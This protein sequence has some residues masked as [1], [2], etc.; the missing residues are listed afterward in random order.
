[1]LQRRYHPSRLDDI[2]DL[3]LYRPGGFHPVSI[4]DVFANGRYKVLHKLGFGG[5]STVWLARDQRPQGQSSVSETLV[6]LKV[7]SAE[8]STKQRDEVAELVIPFKLDAL[9]RAAPNASCATRHNV[10][11]VKDYFM[12]EGPNGTH[13]CIV[14]QFAGSSLLSLSSCP[15]RVS[16]SRRLRSDLARKVAKQ[17]A[18]VIELM[19]SAGLL[20]GD[21]TSSNILF[22]VPDHARRWSD[23]EIYLTLG[24]PE[25]EEIVTL[26]HSP[27]GP[28]APREL[29]EPVGAACLSSPSLLQEDIIV[30][31]FGQSF[32]TNRPPKDYEPATAIHYLS[33]EAR[34]EN[35]ISLASDIWALA[36]IIFEIRAGSPLFDSFFGDDTDIVRETVETL[37]KLP[38]PWWSAFEH[39]SLW[40]EENGKPKPIEIQEQEG[41][42][43]PAIESS[44]RQKLREIGEQD[45]PPYA[46]EGPMMESIGTRLEE[47]EVVLLGDLLEKML[48]YRPEER[49]TIKEVVRHPWFNYT[50]VQ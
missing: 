44:I 34:F 47:G 33:P 41:V 1:M 16:G 45:E 2:E 4:G 13:L 39:R 21:L 31:D 35:R 38:E 25:T 5:S 27:P 12:K 8:K 49:I 30:I 29:V 19:H 28:C 18:T 42:L 46:D 37:G 11:V 43:L 10:Q 15:G 17:I 20:H 36:C 50:S 9:I 7:L 26:D 6:T 3:E 24:E 32:A 40:F 48:R 14:S 22:Q 23:N